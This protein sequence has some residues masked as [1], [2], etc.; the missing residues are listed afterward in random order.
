MIVSWQFVLMILLSSLFLAF[1]LYRPIKATISHEA[2]NIAIN[3]QKQ[4]ELKLDFDHGIIGEAQYHEAQ[5]EIVETL[6]SD[7]NYQYSEEVST[8]FHFTGQ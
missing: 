7:L 2:S 4:E 1:F 6:A 5:D 8:P 3:K